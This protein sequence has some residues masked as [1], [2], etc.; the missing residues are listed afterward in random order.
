MQISATDGA[1]RPQS[2][3]F[4]PTAMTT[5]VKGGKRRNVFKR[6][7]PRKKGIELKDEEST[8]GEK[9][10]PEVASNLVEFHDETSHTV[11]LSFMTASSQSSSPKLRDSPRP[12]EN[13]E[14][15]DV[16]FSNEELPIDDLPLAK[17]IVP[18]LPNDD[19]YSISLIELTKPIKL[20]YFE[21]PVVEEPQ[22]S[23]AP[24]LFPAVQWNDERPAPFDT[25]IQ[26]IDAD[27]GIAVDSLLSNSPARPASAM[28]GSVSPQRIAEIVDEGNDADLR[29]LAEIHIPIDDEDR[30]NLM[31]SPAVNRA[32]E[33]FDG[34]GEVR[35]IIFSELSRGTVQHDWGEHHRRIEEEKKEDDLSSH[36]R[37][38]LAAAVVKLQQPSVPIETELSKSTFAQDESPWS[39]ELWT[40]DSAWTKGMW[41]EDEAAVSESPK[42]PM[43]EKMTTNTE[44]AG[45]DVSAPV[46]D[47]KD[48]PEFPATQSK[49]SPAARM[50]NS[51]VQLRLG[52][53]PAS[54]V[55]SIAVPKST[56]EEQDDN[57]SLLRFL[58]EES[59]DRGTPPPPPPINVTEYSTPDR[60]YSLCETVPIQDAPRSS[61][62]TLRSR[63]RDRAPAAPQGVDTSFETYE[64]SNSYDD[65]DTRSAFTAY[66]AESEKYEPGIS[67]GSLFSSLESLGSK[68]QLQRILERLSV[69]E[70]NAEYVQAKHDEALLGIHE[71]RRK[72]S[73]L[74]KAMMK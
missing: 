50:P 46:V 2:L 71:L 5:R 7:F 69:S 63:S 14:E 41:K 64:Q 4:S 55:H 1:D 25:K 57:D 13:R 21:K 30:I 19:S 29:P 61:R 33:E 62:L 26:V 40:T 59:L 11:G 48:S 66:T 60:V 31:Y 68:E 45:F 73:D 10:S 43:N 9:P 23:E 6:I 18:D 54:P 51:P 47:T 3:L 38:K 49:G 28:P 53:S 27:D 34:Q 67:C 8:P 37:N 70:E 35:D 16:S 36:Q 42:P 58:N 65:D 24:Q 52:A 44:E 20:S 56:P 12:P 74:I 39:T 32:P 15:P 22:E 72:G 17:D